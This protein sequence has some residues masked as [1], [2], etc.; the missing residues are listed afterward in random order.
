MKEKLLWSFLVLSI[1]AV[2]G[3]AAW[4]RFS[5]V[6]TAPP[7]SSAPAALPSAGPAPEFH[8]TDQTGRPFSSRSLDGSVW[9]TDFIFTSCAG[10]CPLMSAQMQRMQALLPAS[11]HLV[12]I[13]VDPKRDTPRR[14]AKYAGQYGADPERWHFLTGPEPVISSL[15]REG[16]RLGYAD[17]SD[18]AEPIIHSQRFV[19]V[20]RAGR[21][22]GYYASDDPLQMERLVRDARSL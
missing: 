12:S 17:G 3:A 2:L 20:D 21:I 9:I 10:A 14:L 5:P 22:R 1:L 19:L 13:S 18:P 7:G 11:V 6:P 16:F 4:R 8:L 15:T